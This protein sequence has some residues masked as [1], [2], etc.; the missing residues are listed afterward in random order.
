[1]IAG[2]LNPKPDTLLGYGIPDM[3]L[4]DMILN[5]F[6]TSDNEVPKY[7]KVFPNPFHSAVTLFSGSGF[8]GEVLLELTTISGVKIFKNRM[9]VEG[10]CRISDWE[11]LPAGS[12]LLK[13]SS[14]NF[15]EAH[16]LI[17]LKL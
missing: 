5:Q 12:Y 13:I 3:H 1:M 2:H 7:W 4:A 8:R 11:H 10:Y 15:T 6:N 9:S 14:G 17:K 16:V